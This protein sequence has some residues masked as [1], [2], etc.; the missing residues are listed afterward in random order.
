MIYKDLYSRIFITVS[1]LIPKKWIQSKYL[2]VRSSQKAFPFIQR[3]TLQP[4][5]SYFR[6]IITDIENT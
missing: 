4:I 6:R 1:F 2:R 5:K 3:L